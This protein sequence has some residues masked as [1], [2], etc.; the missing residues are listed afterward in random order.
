ML[1]SVDNNLLI[2]F[3]WTLANELMNSKTP[4]IYNQVIILFLI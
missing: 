3:V 2:S 1:S 4:S